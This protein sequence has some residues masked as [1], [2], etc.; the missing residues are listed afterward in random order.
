MMM[1]VMITVNDDGDDDHCTLYKMVQ[2]EDWY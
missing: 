1:V 2:K